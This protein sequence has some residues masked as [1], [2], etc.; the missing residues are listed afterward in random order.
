[1]RIY[2]PK[3]WLQVFTFYKHDTFRRLWPILIG[4]GV[5]T[6]AVDFLL[7]KYPEIAAFA[8]LKNLSITHTLLGLVISLLL[9]FRTNTSYERWWEGRKLWGS[10]VNNSRNL[11]LKLN[12]LLSKDDISDRRFF[13]N[14]ISLYAKSLDQHLKS[15][16]LALQLDEYDHP[17]LKEIDMD[18]HLPNQVASFLYRRLYLLEKEGKITS[19]QLLGILPEMASFTDICGA[20]ERIRNTPIPYSYASFIKKFIFLYTITLPWSLAVNLGFISIP[21]VLFVMYALGSLEVIA[22]EI[23]EPFGED[24]ND[25]PTTLMAATINKNMNDIL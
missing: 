22:E 5:Y 15:K 10:L 18:K 21:V 24:S 3:N 20:C 12:G 16:S 17:E 8:P 13:R 25:L 11:A 19:Q 4:L 2:N 23:E 14:F 6:W 7:A 1:M 9:V